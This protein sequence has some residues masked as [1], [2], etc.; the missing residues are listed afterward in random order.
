M[1]LKV[2]LVDGYE[3]IHKI[4]P[5][6]E[7]AFEKQFKGGMAKLFREEERAEHLY[8]LAWECLRRSGQTV[9]PFENGFLDQLDAIE[10]VDDDPNG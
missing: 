4:T 3:G 7:V 2:K 8:W 5:A 6:V 9:R 10:L 1:Q